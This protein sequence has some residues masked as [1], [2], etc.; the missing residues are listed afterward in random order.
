[1]GLISKLRSETMKGKGEEIRRKFLKFTI[2]VK[3]RDEERYHE[4][5]M[6]MKNKLRRDIGKIITRNSKPYRA[7]MRRLKRVADEV[8]EEYRNTYD[9]KI[10]NL[11]RKQEEKK[12]RKEKEIPRE[13]SEYS[14]L[15]IFNNEKF[16]EIQVSKEEILII[17]KDISLS[18][19]KRAILRLHTKFSVIKTLTENEIEFEQEQA[20][21]KIRMERRKEMEEEER[22]EEGK[23]IGPGGPS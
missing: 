22:E 15:S 17:S 13:M 9:E 6:K 20:Y 5:M 7:M 14:D 23:Q 21:A 4:E 10:Y 8:K 11:R 12:K 2:C 18:E 1:M 19:E 3:I 16:E